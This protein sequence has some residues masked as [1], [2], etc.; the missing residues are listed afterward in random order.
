[1]KFELGAQGREAELVGVFEDTFTAS[2]GAEEGALV[3]DLAR[4]LLSHTDAQDLRV[5]VALDES[6]VAGSIL[7]TRLRYAQDPREVFL[8]SPVAV[9]PGWQGKGVGQS[10]INHGLAALKEEGV[11]VVLTY[12]DPA[13]YARVGFAQ[14]STDV[15]TAPLPLSHPHG[16]LGQSLEGEALV[17]L[18]G[19]CTC[20][21]AMDRPEVW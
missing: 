18:Q 20:V 15:A 1:M 6:D 12:G 2:E 13:Y 11:A 8:L 3:G 16:W 17:P 14:I 4:G 10:M 9:R 21:P 19:A 5:V 7:F